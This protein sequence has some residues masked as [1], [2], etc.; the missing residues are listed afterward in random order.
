MYK[1]SLADN[2]ILTIDEQEEIVNWVKK[3]YHKFISTGYHRCFSKIELHNDIPKCVNDIKLRIIEKENLHNEIQEPY[4]KDSIGYMWD[5]GQLHKHTDPNQGELIHTRFNVY[6]QLP[7]T[8]GYP[9]YDNKILRLK[10]RT[11]IC[12]RSGLDLHSCEMAEGSRERII[13]SFGYLLSKERV[14]NIIYEY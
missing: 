9:I 1:Y 12:C 4:F 8:G 13:I 11:Y 5:G 2:Y 14:K 3:N 7:L 6:V 10:E